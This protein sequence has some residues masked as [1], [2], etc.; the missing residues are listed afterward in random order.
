MLS[1][2]DAETGSL[3]IAVIRDITRRKQADEAL[4]EYAERMKVLSRRLIDVQEAERRRVALELHDE[5]GQL[6]TG[7]KLTLEMGARLPGEEIRA[8]IAQAQMVVNELIARTRKLSLDLRPATLDHLG[9][10]SALLRHLTHY[11]AQTQVQ[12]A[13]KHHGLEGRRFAPEVETAA[14]R[15]VQEALTNVARHAGVSEITVRVWADEHNLTVQIEDHGRGFNPEEVLA[16]ST[17]SGLA[18]MRERALLLGGHLTI[19]SR[20]GAGTCV[21][22]E[23]CLSNNPD[24]RSHPAR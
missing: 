6:L 15:I 4:R 12:V 18:G 11:T 24:L 23:W 21:T 19:E 8:S 17:T 16:A 1:P 13:F 20:R 3:V 2:V 5:I 22:A 14:F 10:L 9:L 7:L